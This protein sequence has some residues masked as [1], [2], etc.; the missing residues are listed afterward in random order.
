MGI[1]KW[2]CLCFIIIPITSFSQP[3]IPPFIGLDESAIIHYLD[4]MNTISG[5]LYKA[6]R[7]VAYNGDLILS[8]DYLIKDEHIYGCYLITLKFMRVNGKEICIYQII[9]GSIQYA[10]S[11][12]N[13]IKDNFKYISPKEFELEFNSTFKITASFERDEGE[14]SPSFRIIYEL[15]KI[16]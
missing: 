1:T 7:T 5:H 10:E 13:Y 14:H 6:D 12:L 9:S 8:F 2:M 16:K 3:K 11:H 4:S 15:V